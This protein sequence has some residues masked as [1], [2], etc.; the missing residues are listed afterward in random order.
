MPFADTIAELI[1]QHQA[2]LEALTEN[3]DDARATRQPSPGEWSVSETMLHL[4]GDVASF[5]REIR[6]ALTGWNPPLVLDQ[7]SGMYTSLGA[8]DRSLAALRARLFE[9]LDATK[10]AIAGQSDE[11][12][13]QTLQIE[14]FGDVA[15]GRWLRFNFTQHFSGHVDQ[16]EAAIAAADQR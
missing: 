12:L 2:R 11:A 3:V 14:G 16:I 9:H 1:D 13:G 5:P 6:S 10:A 8:E 15:V 4:V 7:A